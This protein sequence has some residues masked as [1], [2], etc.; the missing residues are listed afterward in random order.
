MR[1]SSFEIRIL[2]DGHNLK[3]RE[4][5]DQETKKDE[6]K[7]ELKEEEKSEKELSDDEL[8]DVAGGRGRVKPGSY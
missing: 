2:T 4:M 8:E 7:E 1:N 6:L 3:E 5:S